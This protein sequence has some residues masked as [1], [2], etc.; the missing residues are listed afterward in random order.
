[1]IRWIFVLFM[2]V[3]STGCSGYHGAVQ[4]APYARHVSAVKLRGTAAR[5]WWSARGRY[6]RVH[7]PAVGSVLVFRATSHMPSGH[8]AV[9][10]QIVTLR[11]ILVDQANW[12]PGE[13]EHHVMV[14]DVSVKA[15]WT[16]VRVWWVPSGRLGRRIY[17]TYGF[18]LPVR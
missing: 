17:P 9:V 16:R 10:R 14:E 13:I 2:I 6:R 8:V 5:W 11:R 7:K 4:C 1:M 18:L 15:N 3:G 12:Q